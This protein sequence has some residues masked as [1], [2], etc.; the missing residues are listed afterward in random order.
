MRFAR[1]HRL[2]RSRRNSKRD[3]KKTLEFHLRPSHP[4]NKTNVL[5]REKR[6]FLE[7]LREKRYFAR[8]RRKI[9]ITKIKLDTI[10][11]NKC[12]INTFNANLLHCLSE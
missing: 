4:H 6:A 9:S 11:E 8:N 5:A 1:K 3:E 2:Y 10:H 7:K 12:A